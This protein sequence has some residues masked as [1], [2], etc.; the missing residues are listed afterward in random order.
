MNLQLFYLLCSLATLIGVSYVNCTSLLDDRP[1]LRLLYSFGG[2]L[3]YAI[4]MY[5]SLPPVEPVQ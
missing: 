3:V 5:L 1:G 2:V 4:F